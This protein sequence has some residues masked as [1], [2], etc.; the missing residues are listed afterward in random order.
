MK[1][2]IQQLETIK[3]KKDMS[4]IKGLLNN[5]P[6]L[7]WVRKYSADNLLANNELAQKYGVA[8]NED[9]ITVSDKT[10]TKLIVTH[11]QYAGKEYVKYNMKHLKEIMDLLGDKGELIIS[12]DNH[13]EMFIQM[14]DTVIVVCPLPKSD[15]AEE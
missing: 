11:S 7:K 1:K 4:W 15:E 9:T 3:V 8:V 5:L 13:K 10:L 2:Q 12:E 14:N 6:L